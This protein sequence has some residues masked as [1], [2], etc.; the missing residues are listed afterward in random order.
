MESSS[1]GVFAD[2]GAGVM[3]G[4]GVGEGEGEGD[5]AGTGLGAEEGAVADAMAKD[6]VFTE[7]P[8]LGTC[9]HPVKTM[10]LIIRKHDT[11]KR[12]RF[13]WGLLFVSFHQQY[14][15]GGNAAQA[16]GERVHK[17]DAKR[18]FR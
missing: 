7:V 1:I 11:E 15:T 5:G 13:I 10:P 6:G 18:A 2:T 16:N 4:T 3:E 12:K 17:N 14:T 9:A 8:A